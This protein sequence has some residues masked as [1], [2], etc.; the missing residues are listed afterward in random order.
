MHLETVLNRWKIM[1]HPHAHPHPQTDKKA[2]EDDDENEHEE[3]RP[4]PVSSRTSPGK[5]RSRTTPHVVAKS[6]L[7]PTNAVGCTFLIR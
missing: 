6:D 3:D 2:S 1:A 5:E 4:S 7:K